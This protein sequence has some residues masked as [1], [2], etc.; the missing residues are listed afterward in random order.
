MVGSEDIILFHADLHSYGRS[1]AVVQVLRIYHF[2]ERLF[3]SIGLDVELAHTQQLT[4]VI[5]A[6]V[7]G[8]SV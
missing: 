6:Q 2:A 3:G 7:T 4:P 5:V 8:L 1:F